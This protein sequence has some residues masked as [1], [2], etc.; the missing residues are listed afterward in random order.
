MALLSTWRTARNI[1]IKWPQGSNYSL[2]LGRVRALIHP[3]RFNPRSLPSLPTFCVCCFRAAPAA[4]GSSLARARIRA[5][6]AGLH[7]SHSHSLTGSDLHLQPTHTTAHGNAGF[8]IHRARP[9]IKPASSWILVEFISPAP[10]QEPFYSRPP[11][12]PSDPHTLQVGNEQR[13]SVTC[14][15]KTSLMPPPL[16]LG[17]HLFAAHPQHLTGPDLVQHQMDYEEQ[18]RVWSGYN[19]SAGTSVE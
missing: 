6:A 17:P 10:Q 1:S 3:G 18:Q 9:G 8:P 12:Q 16:L 19:P 4:Y 7:H 14:L 13:C 2:H 5:G 15:C 11:S